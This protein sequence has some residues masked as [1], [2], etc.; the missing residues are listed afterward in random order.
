[1]QEEC[2]KLSAL[3]IQAAGGKGGNVTV[4]AL[5]L[6]VVSSRKKYD[7]EEEDDMRVVHHVT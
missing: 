5:G 2:G 7:G 6:P 4:I 1:M 3:D